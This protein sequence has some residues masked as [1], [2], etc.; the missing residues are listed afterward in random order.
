M[1]LFNFDIKHIKKSLDSKKANPAKTTGQLLYST[2]L[3]NGLFG[4]FSPYKFHNYYTSFQTIG[5]VQFPINFICSRI[6]NAKFRLKSWEDDSIVWD[7]EKMNKFLENPNPYYS[8]KD[9]VA[10]HTQ[11]KL[12]TGN[13]YLYANI[14]QSL[15][16]SLWE[17]CDSFYILP[18]QSVT[19]KIKNIDVFSVNKIED[20][21]DYYQMTSNGVVKRIPPALIL[22][23]KDNLDFLNYSKITGFPRLDSQ[24]Y[25]LANLVAVYE[26]RNVI[27]TKRGA[28]GAIIGKIKD[29]A[30]VT[31]LTPFEIEELENTFHSDYG[32]DG[33]KHMHLISK[34]P[35]EFVKFGATIKELQPFDETLE[36]AIQI[37]GIFGVSDGLIP[38]KDN[39]TFNNQNTEEVS[40]YNNT[41]IPL[42]STF[43]SELND[44]LGLN[45]SGFYID[46]IWDDITVLKSGQKAEEEKNTIISDRCRQDF[47]NGILTL[48]DWRTRLGMEAIEKPIYNKLILEMNEKELTEI[49]NILAI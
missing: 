32:L 8:F 34:I 42:V 40:V 1:R 30:G 37:A 22:H 17:Y 9:L 10:Y 6:R 33:N 12:I 2:D 36:D 24:Q 43:L 39:S 26:A 31:Q 25:T 3:I 11:M 45:E 28:L 44:F 16:G 5:E 48:N 47:K 35:I 21:V 27:Y 38:R 7:N 46:A 15:S 49:K 4:N 14:D 20:I 13:S 18:S 19:Q 29:D 23:S 41:I